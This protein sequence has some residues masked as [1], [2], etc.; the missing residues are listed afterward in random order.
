MYLHISPEQ[1]MK[2][3]A[4]YARG[5]CKH[6]PNCKN[7]H[8]RQVA[9]ANYLTGF[10]PDGPNCPYGHPKFEL[11][12]EEMDQQ[13]QSMQDKNKKKGMQHITCHK[14][15]QQGHKAVSC[16]NTDS[17]GA[18]T[19]PQ[20]FQTRPQQQFQHHQQQQQHQ[21]HRATRPIESVICF[22]CGNSGHYANNCPTR[23]RT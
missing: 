8:T 12:K 10:C 5:F 16:P 15:G 9:C 23:I 13:N 2:D 6:G 4:W 20:P 7:R 11:P 22:K 18:T 19:Q 1:K 17:G 21:Q 3:C 14:C